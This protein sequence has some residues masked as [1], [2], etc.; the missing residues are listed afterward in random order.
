M[1]AAA[2]GILAIWHDVA[3]GAEREVFDWY[4]REHH[5]ERTAIPGFLSAQRYI[6]VDDRRP[7]IFNRYETTGPE[8]MTSQ[9]YLDCLASPTAWGRRCQPLYRNMSRTVCRITARAGLAQG[10][11]AA[12]L[13]LPSTAR[14]FHETAFRAFA[15]RHGACWGVLAFELWQAEGGVSNAASAERQLRGRDDDVIGGAVV[16]HATSREALDDLIPDMQRDI[17]AATGAD[18]IAGVY[19]LAFS[20]YSRR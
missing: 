16:V 9:A 6:S 18:A 11:F 1:L 4:D 14:S 10:G 15:A 5:L 13:R 7:L 2:K 8:V 20:A 12:T 17:K 19:R 3:E